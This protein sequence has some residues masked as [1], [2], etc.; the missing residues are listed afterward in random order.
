MTHGQ[1]VQ[2]MITKVEEERDKY[3]AKFEEKRK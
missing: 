2:M 1:E 3:A